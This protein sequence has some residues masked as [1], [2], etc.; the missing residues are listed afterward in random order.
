MAEVGA[1][2]LDV[3]A[4]VREVAG[5]AADR[6][7]GVLDQLGQA[8]AVVLGQVDRAV[9]LLGRPQLLDGLLERG[10]MAVGGGRR[11]GDGLQ[12]AECGLGGPIDEVQPEGLV[13]E[14]ADAVVAEEV[15]VGED[16]DAAGAVLCDGRDGRRAGRDAVAKVRA[17]TWPPLWRASVP[18]R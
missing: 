8:G 4:L 15:G 17:R 11:V 6:G 3:F 14:L 5:E 18:E 7:A 12:A 9:R 13:V 10:P 2:G 16:D 1:Q